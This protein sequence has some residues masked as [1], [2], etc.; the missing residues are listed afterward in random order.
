MTCDEWK[1]D[2]DV[3]LNAA[4]AV[5]KERERVL[6]N[7]GYLCALLPEGVVWGDPIT[8]DMVIEIVKAADRAAREECAAM[9]DAYETDEMDWLA[10]EIRET[11][12]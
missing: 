11:M 2:D 3:W 8:P 10:K 7:F 6:I 9:A 1:R 5:A 4:M 12:K